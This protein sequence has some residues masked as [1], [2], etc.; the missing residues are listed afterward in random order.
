MEL[1]AIRKQR[2]NQ[3]FQPS[4]V[5]KRC[6]KPGHWWKE[7][8]E[9]FNIRTASADELAEH[10]AFVQ[11]MWELRMK[12]EAMTETPSETTTNSEDFDDASE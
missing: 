12:E 4:G 9:P 3:A 11:D 2:Q 6:K 7:C 5:C 1:D 10:Q 8:P